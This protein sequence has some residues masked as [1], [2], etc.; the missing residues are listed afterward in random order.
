MKSKLFVWRTG[1]HGA[2]RDRQYEGRL[3]EAQCLELYQQWNIA[4]R[5]VGVMVKNH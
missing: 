5:E 2:D 4:K 3:A 1:T